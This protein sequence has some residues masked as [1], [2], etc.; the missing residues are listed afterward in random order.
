MARIG[1]LRRKK[2]SRY[3]KS[4]KQKGKISLRR[5]LSE[6]KE[7][8]R[9]SLTIEPAVHE[10]TYCPRFAGKSGTI[11]SRKGTCYEVKIKDFNKEKILI[12]HP[13]HMRKLE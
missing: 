4:T 12:V 13:V 5:Y 3:T 11:M 7:G 9:V 10:G 2:V 6:F 1:G 8:D